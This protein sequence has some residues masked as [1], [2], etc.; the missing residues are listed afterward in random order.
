MSQFN[1]GIHIARNALLTENYVS[2]FIA[3]AQ[4]RPKLISK[5]HNYEVQ[6]MYQRLLW[7]SA[8][9]A[10]EHDMHGVRSSSAQVTYI[11]RLQFLQMVRT[12]RPTLSIT[13]T[14]TEV[15]AQ[16]KSMVG[17]HRLS[18]GRQKRWKSKVEVTGVK[19]SSFQH[20]SRPVAR[21]F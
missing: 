2:P 6:E 15:K 1:A 3:L 13:V 14:E 12:Y 20:V 5:L 7:R 21:V 9:Q 19:P 4:V 10:L 8:A 18:T 16:G 11:F 17:D